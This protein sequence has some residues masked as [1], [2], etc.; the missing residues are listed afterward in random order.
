MTNI[1][2]WHLASEE[3]YTLHVIALVV[4]TL[5]RIRPATGRTLT[6]IADPRIQDSFENSHLSEFPM[7]SLE[8]FTDIILPAALWPWGRLSL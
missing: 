7:V 5:V 1:L 6:F 3:L 2:V 8:F 4:M